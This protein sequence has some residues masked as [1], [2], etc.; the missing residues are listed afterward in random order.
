MVATPS[1]MKVYDAPHSV[2]S[3]NSSASSRAIVGFRES[4]FS[5][6]VVPLSTAVEMEHYMARM[7]DASLRVEVW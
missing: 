1:L 2:A 6:S 7:L 4:A 3:N 5:I